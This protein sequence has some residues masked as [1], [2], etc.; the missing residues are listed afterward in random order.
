MESFLYYSKSIM[1]EHK[2]SIQIYKSKDGETQLEV[3]LDQENIW[4]S[5]EQIAKLF[6]VNRQAITKHIYNIFK[7]WELSKEWTCSILE[8]VKT[9]GGRLVVRSI[10]LY[11]LDVSISIGY[12]VNS[13]K[14][15]HFR[16]RATNKLKEHLVH[17]YTLNQSRIKE[18]WIHQ[19][20]RAIELVKEALE[21]KS[22]ISHDETQW[23]LEVITRYSQSWLLLYQYDQGEFPTKGSTVIPI[24][25][26][27]ATQANFA[28]K[29][30]KN[31]LIE[32]WTA[33]DLFALPKYS[34]TLQ[35]IFGNIYQSFDGKELY[36]SVE[37]K[38]AHLLYFIIKDHPFNDGNKRS[39]AF[40]FILFLQQ[41]GILYDRSG[42][43]K[44]NDK[45]LVALALLIAQ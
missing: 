17:G 14:A 20:Q 40:L 39:G 42:N 4:L 38:A 21:K 27:Q 3:Q 36:P 29:E 7:T 23:L 13:Q 1:D 15:T 12:R 44:I 34:G 45:W 28:L 9:E 8:Q 22:D 37:E 19:L 43:S 6:G 33:S 2:G 41:Y 16:Q 5:Q 35:W 31:N 32:Q 30:L 18:T 11:N 25:K 10:K 26:L 24:H